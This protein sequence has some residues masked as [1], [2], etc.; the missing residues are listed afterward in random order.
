MTK[1][2]GWHPLLLNAG[3]LGFSLADVQA[4]L[5]VLLI[6]ASLVYT[7]IKILMACKNKKKH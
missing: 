2:N 1:L 5:T 6:G 7:V 3:V 4:V